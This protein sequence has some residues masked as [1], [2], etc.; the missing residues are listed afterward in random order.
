M[1]RALTTAHLCVLLIFN[2]EAQEIF[3]EDNDQFVRSLDESYVGLLFLQSTQNEDG[4]W[5]DNF[6]WISTRGRYDCS[7]FSIN[8]G[9]DPELELSPNQ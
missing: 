1:K 7:C 2:A 9:D 4:S 8:A 3:E 6:L 5:P